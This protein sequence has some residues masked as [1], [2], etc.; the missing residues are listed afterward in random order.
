MGLGLFKPSSCCTGTY[1][2]PTPNP[3]PKN[4]HILHHAVMGRYV[5]LIVKYPECTTFEGKKILV[6]RD[7]GIKTLRAMTEIDPHFCDDH[8]HPSP[9]ARFRPDE[10]GWEDAVR[11]CAS[12]G[13]PL[14]PKDAT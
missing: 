8:T 11:F 1:S 3:N 14:V 12:V 13:T 4:F 6:F 2:P 10:Q 5:L 7:V 9:V